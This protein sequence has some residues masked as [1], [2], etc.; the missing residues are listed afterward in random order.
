M[1]SK[2]TALPSKSKHN[3]ALK[4][5]KH[6]TVSSRHFYAQICDN[7]VLESHHLRLLQ[8]L[9]EAFDRGQEARK[10]LAQEVLTV[11]DSKLGIKR[12]HPCVSIER[13]SRTAVARLTRELNLSEEPDDSRPPSLRY[14]GKR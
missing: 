3:G 6:L 4:I 13:D 8:L 9:C 7:F 14:G 11:V 1:S 12:P 10:L 5:P 2:I